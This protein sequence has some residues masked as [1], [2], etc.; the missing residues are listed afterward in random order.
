MVKVRHGWE[1]QNIRELENL[2]SNQVSPISAVSEHR[3]LHAVPFTSDI[4]LYSPP[5]MQQDSHD[6]PALTYGNASPRQAIFDAA[7]R[8]QEEGQ[9]NHVRPSPQIGAGYESFWREHKG[10]SAPTAM[11]NRPSL[12][13]PVDLL[14]LDARNSDFASRR[15]PALSTNDIGNPKSQPLLRTPSPK[16]SSQMR[17]ASQQAAVEKDVVETLLFMSSPVNSGYYPPSLP[18]GT[19]LRSE[20]MPQMTYDARHGVSPIRESRRDMSNF[21][22]IPGQA[23]V[24]SRQPLSDAQI[25]EMLDEAPDT[26]S[27]D[28]DLPQH[29]RLQ[30]VPPPR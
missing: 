2:T 5:I 19:P 3:P 28:E 21:E 4:S 13:P 15:P 11:P 1:S 26:S 20:F 9:T 17:T 8:K 16:K 24:V 14:P 12:A 25:N 27:S 18:S 7:C 30:Q 22:A 29:S 10:D 23:Q 6:P